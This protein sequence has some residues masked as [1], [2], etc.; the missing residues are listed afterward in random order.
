MT[1][2]PQTFIDE[3]K[4]QEAVNVQVRAVLIDK[5]KAVL[6]S[7]HWSQ[8]QAAKLCGLTQP[9]ISDFL[10]GNIARFSLDTLVN[11]TAAL[12]RHSQ[13][14]EGK[15]MDYTE[16]EAQ[17]LVA[18][19]AAKAAERPV[20][21]RYPAAT[22]NSTTE[23]G[24]KIVATSGISMLGCCVALVGDIVCYPDGS[25]TKI[26]S[27]AGAAMIYRGRPMAVVGSELENGDRIN[28]PTHSGMSIVQYAD[29][30]PIKGLLDRNYVLLQPNDG[31]VNDE[32]A[33]SLRGF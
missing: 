1:F 26:V 18:E 5:I 17:R 33:N 11:I 24:G 27:G 8:R 22:E 20:K 25:Q 13:P 4:P 9:R 15:S 32:I 12:E 31:P 2:T 29:R 28:G 14:R 6:V 23:R 19:F 7:K 16:E 3:N 21:A 30:E 10:R